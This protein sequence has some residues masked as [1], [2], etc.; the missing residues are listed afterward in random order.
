MFENT[1]ILP[2]KFSLLKLAPLQKFYNFNAYLDQNCSCLNFRVV[3]RVVWITFCTSLPVSIDRVPTRRF[4]LTSQNVVT[5]LTLA[6][7][8]RHRKHVSSAIM[9]SYTVKTS[10]GHIAKNVQG[11]TP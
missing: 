5:V 10:N 7:S 9:V 3:Y 4:C 11:S 1:E 6:V 8:A 2:L